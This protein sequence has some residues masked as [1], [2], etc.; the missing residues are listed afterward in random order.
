MFPNE[1]QAKA[2]RQ[3]RLEEADHERLLKLVQNGSSPPKFLPSLLDRIRA[4]IRQLSKRDGKDPAE[5]RR[6][7]P[8]GYSKGD[9]V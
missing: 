4:F 5:I 7:K 9:A 8:L 6:R 3:R 1:Y 2:Y